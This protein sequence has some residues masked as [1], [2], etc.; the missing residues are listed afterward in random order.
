MSI[1]KLLK[2]RLRSFYNKIIL[3]YNEAMC[4]V[5]LDF[6]LAALLS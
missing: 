2:L 6:K 4:L 1:K 5:N 3:S